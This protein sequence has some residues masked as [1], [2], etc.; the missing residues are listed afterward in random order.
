MIGQDA[1]D[2]IVVVEAFAGDAVTQVRR[3]AERA[4][5]LPQL[6]DGRPLGEVAVAGVHTDDAAGCRPQQLHRVVAGHDG[7]GWIVLHPEIFAVGNGV[8]DLQENV[9]LLGEFGVFPEAVLVV[10]LHA[11]HHVVFPRDRQQLRD[12]LDHPGDALFAADLRVALAAEDAAHR[13]RPAQPPTDADHLGLAVQG[14]FTAVRV[15]VGEVGRAAEHRHGEAGGAD[16]LADAVEVGGFEAGEKAVVHLQA[17]GV[18][19]PGHVDPVEDRHRPG[20]GDL[21]EIALREGGD[22]QGHKRSY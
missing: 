10:V 19:R 14:A 20:A 22:F 5:A 11:E 9:L 1:K 7:V 3:I 12:R 13:L 21:V 15:G 8:D 18:E 6:V 2:G 16:R 4:V 17:V